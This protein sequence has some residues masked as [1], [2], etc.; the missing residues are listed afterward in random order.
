MIGYRSNRST[1]VILHVIQYTD[2]QLE[3]MSEE[4]HCYDSSNDKASFIFL[5]PYKCDDFIK[6]WEIDLTPDK[7]DLDFILKLSI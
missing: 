7:K 3:E 4:A 6:N 1:A 5:E 2:E